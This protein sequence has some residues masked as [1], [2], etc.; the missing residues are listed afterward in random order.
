M[1]LN[2]RVEMSRSRRSGSRRSGEGTEMLAGAV[3]GKASTHETHE[4]HDGQQHNHDTLVRVR[5]GASVQRLA[6]LVC[7]PS[8][9]LKASLDNR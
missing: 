3:R 2:S 1:L 5:T 4:T 8:V 7:R 9:D 6:H